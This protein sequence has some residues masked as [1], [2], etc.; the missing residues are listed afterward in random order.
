MNHTIEAETQQNDKSSAEGAPSRLFSGRALSGKAQK[1]KAGGTKIG[2]LDHTGPS[3]GG[4]QLV[5]GYLAAVLSR[6]YQVDLIGEWKKFG[7]EKIASAFS[8]DLSRVRQ[9]CFANTSAGFGVPGEY[10]LLRQ[11]KRSR[12]LTEPY[13]LFIYSGQGAPPLCRAQHG[14][15]YCHFPIE[16]SP[17]VEAKENPT[18]RQRTSLDQWLRSNAYQFVWRARMRS[19]DLI[20]A[21]SSF[22]AGWIKRRWGMHAE[23]VYPPVDLPVPCASKENLIV[24][25]GR[26]DGVN[27]RKGHL[28]QVQAFR[29][30][31]TSEETWKLCLVGSCFGPEDQAT[32]DS[33]RQAAGGLPVEFA[34]NAE[35]STVSS[36][37]AKAKIFW[38]TAGLYHDEQEKPYKAEHF[39]IA[40]VEAMRA[41]CT[42][43]VIA[44]GGQSEI[45]QQG[46]NGVLCKDLGDLVETTKSM[47]RNDDVLAAFGERARQRSAAFTGSAFERNIREIISRCLEIGHN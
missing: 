35:R 16:A 34:V 17:D 42:P 7:V 21:N 24:S 1:N 2:I 23:I 32:V 4:A 26:F 25:V 46:V 3:L 39:G 44:S 41:G 28:A 6:S 13:D 22:T 40:T 47:A 45:I 18:W 15:V 12:D 30:F 27:G 11:F 10:G 37:L 8:L 14:L 38:H 5:A 29:Q 9:R 36:L 33:L 31:V 20:L 19:Y 43:I